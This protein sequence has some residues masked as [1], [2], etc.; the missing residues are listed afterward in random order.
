MT[1]ATIKYHASIYELGKLYYEMGYL[2]PA[3][4]IFGGL[5]RIDSGGTPS[6]IGL[7]LIKLEGGL[8][9]EAAYYFRLSLEA[10]NYLVQAKLGL[11][12]CFIATSD[13]PRAEILL[14]Q[15]E[16]EHLSELSYNSGLSRLFKSL[17]IRA[18]R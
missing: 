18:G 1:E 6:R 16:K 2:A 9:E 17:K 4:R 11:S 7:G 15:I 5:S 13:T 8:F 14:G 3:E 12:L 10:G